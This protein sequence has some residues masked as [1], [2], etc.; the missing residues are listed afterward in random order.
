MWW[1]LD[2]PATEDVDETLE[3]TLDLIARSEVGGSGVSGFRP[4][5]FID[6]DGLRAFD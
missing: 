6:E 1:P 2:D 3:K 4:R 5:F